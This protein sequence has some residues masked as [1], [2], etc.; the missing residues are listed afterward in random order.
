M[1]E[2]YPA[3]HYCLT[4]SDMARIGFPL[5]SMVER[6][7]IVDESAHSAAA[8]AAWGP[9][10]GDFVGASAPLLGMRHVSSLCSLFG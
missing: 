3:A 5:P 6:N 8:T 7:F 10:T 9:P 4:W 1:S 2:L